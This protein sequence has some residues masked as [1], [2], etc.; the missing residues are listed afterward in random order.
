MGLTVNAYHLLE[1]IMEVNYMWAAGITL[2][3]GSYSCSCKGT[4]E[5][6]LHS[7]CNLVFP[8]GYDLSFCLRSKP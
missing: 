6:K 4:A 8:A 2:A 3:R 1:D 5:V 7:F